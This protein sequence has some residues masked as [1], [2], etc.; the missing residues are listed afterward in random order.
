MPPKLSFKDAVLAAIAGG[1]SSIEEI[2]N[3]LMV[4]EDMVRRVI[5][6]LKRSGL[7]EEVERGFW[8]FKRK[9]LR[10]TEDGRV[11]A[12]ETLERLRRVAEEIRS[13]VSEELGPEEVQKIIEPY[14]PAL[15][16]LFYLGLLDLL[17]LES[18]FLLPS[19]VF[20]DFGDFGGDVRLE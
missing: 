13:K 9:V 7:V 6:E 11:R 1:A 20:W 19:L 4:K 15:P 5:D 8:I 14:A 16:L 2:A 17:L 12:E 3:A 18:L 10:L